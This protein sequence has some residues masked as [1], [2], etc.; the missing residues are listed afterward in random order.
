MTVVDAARNLNRVEA[1]MTTTDEESKGSI[2]MT[3]VARKNRS[4]QQNKETANAEPTRAATMEMST[5]IGIIITI[6]IINTSLRANSTFVRIST[7]MIIT[8]VSMVTTSPN[9]ACTDNIA[10]PAPSNDG[11]NRDD[12]LLIAGRVAK[13]CQVRYNLGYQMLGK[14]NPGRNLYV[15]FLDLCVPMV[16]TVISTRVRTLIL[17]TEEE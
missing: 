13:T 9:D 3:V 2:A 1:S 15:W 14:V 17:P 10:R 11:R 7:L 16:L 6:N 5:K 8:L 12:M 4:R